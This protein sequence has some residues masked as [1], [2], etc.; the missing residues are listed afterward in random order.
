MAYALCNL[1]NWILSLSFS[2][3]L[4]SKYVIP[5]ETRYPKPAILHRT[6]KCWGSPHRVVH[7]FM[8]CVLST[9][10]PHQNLNF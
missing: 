6:L 3:I 2:P 1:S 9:Y 5:L 7:P 4:K 8:E 10:K